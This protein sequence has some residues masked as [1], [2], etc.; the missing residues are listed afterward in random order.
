M[1]WR[2]KLDARDVDGAA[3]A[4]LAAAVGY[5]VTVLAAGALA[6]VMSPPLFILVYAMLRQ[7]G[8]EPPHRLPEFQLQALDSPRPSS[9]VSNDDK[10]IV[11]LFEPPRPISAA[12]AAKTAGDAGRALSEALAALRRS[13]R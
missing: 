12:P 9:A 13:L 11:R 4:I 7:V 10:T 3:A 8:H 2:C 5:A 6:A 1:A